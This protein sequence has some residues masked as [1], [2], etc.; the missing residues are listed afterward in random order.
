MTTTADTAP[1][2]PDLRSGAAPGPPASGA[3]A[4]GPP[5]EGPARGRRGGGPGLP[6]GTRFLLLAAALI[7]VPMAAAIAVTAWRAQQVAGLAVADAL[8]QAHSARTAFDRQRARQLR[9]IARLV[10]QDPAFVAYVAEGDPLSTADLL[11]ER[12]RS[13]DCDFAIVLDPAGRVIARTDRPGRAGDDLSGDPLVAEALRAGE[14]SGVWRDGGRLYAAVASP[15]LSGLRT[16]EGVLVAGFALDDAV[17]LELKRVAGADVCFVAGDSAAARVTASTLGAGGDALAA[18]L[19]DALPRVLAGE[20]AVL[21]R[22]WLERRA[23]GARVEPL[24]DAAGGPVGAVVTLASLDAA[25][26]PYRRIEGALLAVGAL[27]MLAAFAVSWA[28]ARRLSGPLERLAAAAESAREGRLDAP[29]ETGGGDEVGRLARAFHSLLAELR[30]ERETAAFLAARARALRE[31][32]AAPTRADGALA[33]GT[34]LG[35]RFEVLSTL[36]SGGMGVVYLARD[37]EVQ[38]LVALKT[39]HP[40]R[41]GAGDLERLKTELRL[42]RRITHP[43]VVRVHDFGQVDGVPFISMEYVEGVTLRALLRAGVP[44]LPVALRVARQVAA[45]LEA[46]HEFGVLHRDLKPENV[47]FEP[48]GRVKLMDFGIARAAR[49]APEEGAFAGT[50]GY[51]AP[52]VM[53]GREAGAPSDVFSFGVMLHELITGRRPWPGTDPRELMY[54]M[55]H[56][57]PPPLDARGARVPASLAAIVRGCL[58]RAPEARYADAHALRAALEE[59]RLA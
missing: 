1:L 59:V 33:P 28:A 3:A 32:P 7:G 16:P 38:D 10:A 47:V 15:L 48:A 21:P 23:W 46:A 57:P 9:L 6:L 50:L 12:R 19:G 42:A 44:P 56:E 29:L 24:R 34:V 37:R 20:R 43:H 39:L 14:A 31:A 5:P 27:A 45:G 40:A 11:A 52:E 25:L 58:A 8:E 51:A 22:V 2:P 35:G 54:R 53:E 13:L 4:D 30:E 41:A 55:L 49:H 18:A 36:G 26:A 17:A